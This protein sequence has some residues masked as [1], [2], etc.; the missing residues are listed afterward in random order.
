MTSAVF[1]KKLAAKLKVIGKG[2]AASESFLAELSPANIE[3]TLLD[4]I[5]GIQGEDE[6]IALGSIGMLVELID[7]LV[8]EDYQTNELPLVDELDVLQDDGIIDDP[9]LE[10]MIVNLISDRSFVYLFFEGHFKALELHADDS[11]LCQWLGLSMFCYYRTVEIEE[12]DLFNYY[13]VLT[14]IIQSEKTDLT[15][16]AFLKLIADDI[17]RQILP[18]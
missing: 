8:E 14:E 11:L 10:D 3:T 16:A 9:D 6:Q 12:D 17:K 2:I 5:I 13:E 7:N 1:S 15:V 4:L 18:D